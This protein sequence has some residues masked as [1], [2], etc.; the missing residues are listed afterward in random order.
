[1]APLVT[2]SIPSR[3]VSAWIASMIV[4]GPLP[5]CH[6]SASRASCISTSF[7]AAAGWKSA[8]WAMP[9]IR[10]C[11]RKG[12]RAPRVGAGRW[13]GVGGDCV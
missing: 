2:K 1:M 9:T 8:R 6:L 7:P 12:G 5:A 10:C 4:P 11:I 3:R 13:S